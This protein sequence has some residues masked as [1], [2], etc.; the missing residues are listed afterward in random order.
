MI[1]FNELRHYVRNALV[2]YDYHAWT[3]QGLGM[4]RAYLDPERKYRLHLWN[5][6]ARFEGV[7]EI[8]DHPWDFSSYV[9]SGYIEDTR[10]D[11]I[12]SGDANTSLQATHEA[13]LI[14]CGP[15]GCAHGKR[16]RVHLV[17]RGVQ[18]YSAGQGYSARSDAIH[19]SRASQ[20]AVSVIERSGDTGRAH[21]FCELGKPWVSAETRPATRA[22]IREYVDLALAN[23]EQ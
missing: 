6:K 14:E 11:A 16:R 9:L 19:L 2:H 12:W 7:T 21:V 4:M 3:I 8:H 17:P 18:V 10:F 5:Q 15:G 1:E 23:W 22:E 13:Q 20:G